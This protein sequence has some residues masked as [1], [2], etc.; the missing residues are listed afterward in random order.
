MRSAFESAGSGWEIDPNENLYFLGI[1]GTQGFAKPW[2]ASFR[3]ITVR[4]AL[5]RIAEQ[6]GATYGWQIGGTANQRMIMF[7]Y[8]L[9][10]RPNSKVIT[11]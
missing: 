9:G 11:N 1:G 2:T 3:N 7:H 10:V 5:N 8:K 6:L 4:Q